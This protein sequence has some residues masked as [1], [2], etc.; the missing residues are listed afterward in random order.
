MPDVPTVAEL[1]FPGY[2]F[3][4]WVGM[5]VPVGTPQ[6][7]IL[8]LQEATARALAHPS[9]RAALRDQGAVPV[10]S[11]P[12]KFRSFIES[13]IKKSDQI[14]ARASVHLD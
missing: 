13:E 7:A 1:G 6:E 11:S 8:R 10:G 2:D 14:V 3:G 4:T 9:V 5:S 12:E